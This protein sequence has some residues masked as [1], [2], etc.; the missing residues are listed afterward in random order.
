M[1][2]IKHD[3]KTFD[4]PAF[5]LGAFKAA[6]EATAKRTDQVETVKIFAETSEGTDEFILPA[7]MWQEFMGMIGA[8]PPPEAP[9]PVD[10]IP[11]EPADAEEDPMKPTPEEKPQ[12]QGFA[13]AKATADRLDVLEKARKDDAVKARADMAEVIDRKDREARQ[14]ADTERKAGKILGES[15][16]YADSDTWQVAHA[17]IKKVDEDRAKNLEGDLKTARDSKAT[18][19]DRARAQGTLLG[20]FDAVVSRASNEADQSAKVLEGIFRADA[21]DKKSEDPVDASRAAYLDRLNTGK[22]KKSGAEAG[23]AA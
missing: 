20:H 19:T 16:G 2:K 11:A 6:H 23:S 7:S 13:D 5:L 18:E 1:F 17:A 8:V 15:F 21:D 4:A 14:R 22:K 12:P 9:A 3:K 10:E